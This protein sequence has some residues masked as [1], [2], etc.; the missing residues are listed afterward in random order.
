[1][2][3]NTVYYYLLIGNCKEES[4]VTI[5]NLMNSIV[6]RNLTESNII[7]YQFQVAA[8]AE[9]NGEVIMGER[10]EVRISEMVP[11]LPT[12]CTGPSKIYLAV[13]LILWGS[14]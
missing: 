14:N 9:I 7:D 10:S 11:S 4:N 13:I 12:I 1:M 2:I 5:P 6:I 8:T 3:I